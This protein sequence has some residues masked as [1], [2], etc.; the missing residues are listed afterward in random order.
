MYHRI[1]DTKI[2]SS[3]VKIASPPDEQQNSALVLGVLGGGLGEWAWA[4]A[5]GQDTSGSRDKFVQLHG[6][7]K[8]VLWL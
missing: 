1:Q 6:L 8:G 4:W 3:G 5:A 7:T 2:V